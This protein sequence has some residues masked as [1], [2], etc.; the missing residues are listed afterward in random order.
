MQ[1]RAFRNIK[2]C[3]FHVLVVDLYDWLIQVSRDTYPISMP[4][5]Y[6]FIVDLSNRDRYKIVLDVWM[7]DTIVTL[8]KAHSVKM[9]LCTR[10]RLI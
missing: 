6:Q 4:L 7:R 10:S 2:I 8:H 3:L 5:G 9:G 1:E